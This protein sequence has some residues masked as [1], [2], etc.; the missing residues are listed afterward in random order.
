MKD[1]FQALITGFDISVLRFLSAIVFNNL[2][3]LFLSQSTEVVV[4]KCSVRKFFRE[5]CVRIN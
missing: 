5:F 4:G 3:C 2:L 1:D